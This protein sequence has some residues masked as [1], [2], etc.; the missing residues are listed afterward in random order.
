MKYIL[1]SSRKRLH[2]VFLIGIIR[3][4]LGA[5]TSIGISSKTSSFGGTLAQPPGVAL[6][7][8]HFPQGIFDLLTSIP[9]VMGS[10]ISH[11]LQ[12]NKTGL[13]A[14]NGLANATATLKKPDLRCRNALGMRTL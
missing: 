1:Q 12:S 13:A 7:F 10:A 14:I 8:V 9:Q 3:T 5:L 2:K 6:F 4:V 11:M